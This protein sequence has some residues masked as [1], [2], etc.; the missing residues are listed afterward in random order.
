MEWPVIL[1]VRITFPCLLKSDLVISTH[2]T[3]HSLSAHQ[4]TMFCLA[5]WQTLQRG[6]F[7]RLTAIV[8]NAAIARSTKDE[9]GSGTARMCKETSW[10]VLYAMPEKFT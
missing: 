8:A 10:P 7:R 3:S 4:L 9:A 2:S 1:V 6:I 5:R